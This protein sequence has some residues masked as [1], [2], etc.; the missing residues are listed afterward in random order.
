M[1]SVWFVIFLVSMGFCSA[2][3][4]RVGHLLRANDAKGAI[5]GILFGEFYC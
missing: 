2:L 1:Y 3:T 4:V 5:F